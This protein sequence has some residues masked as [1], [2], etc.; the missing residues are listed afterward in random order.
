MLQ[1]HNNSRILVAKTINIFF[2]FFFLFSL[3]AQ[4]DLVWSGGAQAD[5]SFAILLWV[6]SKHMDLE[7]SE[8]ERI[9]GSQRDFSTHI[10]LAT[11]SQIVSTLGE[12]RKSGLP[13]V[14]DYPVLSLLYLHSEKI[15][16]WQFYQPGFISSDIY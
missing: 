7:V 16:T 13:W 3:D 11:L 8:R 15:Q 2:L 6:H 5:R 12:F 9:G 1:L 4:R 14:C 10:P